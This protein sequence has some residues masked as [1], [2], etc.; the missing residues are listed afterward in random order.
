MKE[1]SMPK[2]IVQESWRI[3]KDK[4]SRYLSA[5]LIGTASAFAGG[6]LAANYSENNALAMGYAS[7]VAETAGFYGSMLVKQVYHDASEARQMQQSYGFNG[8]TKTL[9]DLTLEFGLAELIDTPLIRPGAKAASAHLL[10]PEAGILV[11][12]FIGDVAFFLI[13]GTCHELKKRKER[14][15]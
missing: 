15:Q 11:G 9:K 2:R 7:T 13:S 10:G 1:Q 6:A 14:K 12:K 8:L 4:F 5:E 3:A